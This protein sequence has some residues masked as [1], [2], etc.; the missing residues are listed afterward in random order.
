MKT[1][2]I[3][4]ILGLGLAAALAFSLGAGLVTPASAGVQEWDTI[5]TPSWEDNVIAPGTDIFDYAVGPD[6]ETIYATG[7]ITTVD[8]KSVPPTL[9]GTLHG[10]TGS[11]DIDD[12]AATISVV[13]DYMAEI[14][15]WFEGD[16]NY[17]F[18]D[19]TFVTYDQGDV[20][21]AAVT[22]TITGNPA[23][24]DDD[25]MMEFSGYLYSADGDFDDPGWDVELDDIEGSICVEDFLTE[26][27]ITD[28]DIV[29]DG[30]L[31]ETVCTEG[32]F[33]QP[34]VWK[35]TDAG[36]TWDDITADVQDADNLPGPFIMMSYGGVDVAPD[37]QD[38]A[39]I[40]GII[41]DPD[42]H[43]MGFI[44]P[45]VVATQDGTNFSY[46][47]AMEDNSYGSAMALIADIAVSPEVDNIHNIAVGGL[48][49]DVPH[50]PLLYGS[51]YRLE[52][53]TWLSSSWE[54]TTQYV[55]MTSPA[56]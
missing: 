13:S 12:G 34:R 3:A 2:K 33:T 35:S 36:I 39:A 44:R 26:I 37:D 5:T 9:N 49:I 6:G 10:I 8:T 23:C 27:C 54:D 16:T 29:G 4:K 53:G 42:L 15:G 31:P 22:G 47:G 14:E 41:L 1:R 38:W 24:D 30:D 11:F 40:G 48:A 50:T 21:L 20:T 51:V 43:D 52:A 18:G 7:A 45:G 28:A 56:S 25:D 32:L 17:L 19:F 55:D 46:T